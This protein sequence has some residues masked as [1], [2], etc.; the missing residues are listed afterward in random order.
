MTFFHKKRQVSTE[1]KAKNNFW[2]IVFKIILVLILLGSILVLGVFA[3]IAKDLP[4]PGNL[5]N[6]V[7][8]ESTKIYD[9]TGD[10]LLYDVHG[11]EKR[12]VI[13]FSE[14]PDVVKY[15][16]ISLEDQDFYTHHGIKITSILRSILKDIITLDKSQGGSTITQ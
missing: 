13:A 15:A 8:I 7:I 2:L 4:N 6:R 5:T 10:H 14:M 12:T 16:T 3:Y 11:E 9:R 1:N